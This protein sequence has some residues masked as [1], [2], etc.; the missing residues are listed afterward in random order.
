VIRASCEFEI[1]RVHRQRMTP[2]DEVGRSLTQ[3]NA[4]VQWILIQVVTMSYRRCIF[5][6]CGV[7]AM[8]LLCLLV[9]RLEAGDLAVLE[10]GKRVYDQHCAACHG[11][12]GDGNGPAAVWLFPKPRD[13]SAGLYKIQST[14]AGS[15]PSDADLYRSI[16]QG[17]GG[18]S[19]PAFHYL[20]EQELLDVVE[21]VKLLTAVVGPDGRRVNRF[22]EA[23]AN[24]TLGDP[25]TVPPEPPLTFDSIT[26]GQ[27]VYGQMQCN[28]CHG[29]TGA[30]DGPSAP[31]LKDSLGVVI[32]PRDFNTDL[33]RG[34]ST[35]Q[36]LYT[37]IAVGLG[38]TP[39]VAYPD[40]ILTPSDRWALVH[41]IQSLRRKDVEV[42]DILAS[43]GVLPVARVKGD[44]PLDPMDPAWERVESV[45]VPLNPLWP[46]P[47]PI[48]GV[49]VRAL[50]NGKVLA[51]LL[52]WRDDI[53]DGAPV[54]VEDFQDA[55]ALQFSLTDQAPF[56]GMGDPAE[57]GECVAVEGRLAAGHGWGTTRCRSHLPCDA[58]RHLSGAGVARALPDGRNRRQSSGVHRMPSPVEDAN[59]TGFGTMTSQ[60]P[61]AQNVGGKGIWRDGFWSVLF[62]RE[63]ESRDSGDVNLI[64]G[65]SNLVAFA[66]WNGAQ[67]DRNGRK[68]FS[69]WHSMILNP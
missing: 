54:R 11:T 24:G 15:L 57:P 47:Y 14:P 63:L 53:L 60:P 52:Q 67:R 65:E 9:H 26:R 40:E 17:L 68:V 50:H 27:E 56:L 58:C 55:A 8:T 37:R 4:G 29:E 2:R 7:L 3:I 10:A 12:D 32:H 5:P 6:C 48:T 35:G 23:A 61:S 33:F 45:R 39:M 46:E 28:S 34:G 16:S 22:E 25:I 59:A 62:H 38:G 1:H 42:G 13:F 31:T 18:S 30:G 66:I 36:D 20:S 49:T 64:P 19:M 43:D 41:Y 44:L 51:V 21:Y 69:N